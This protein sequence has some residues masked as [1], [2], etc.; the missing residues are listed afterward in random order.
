MGRKKR[1]RQNKQRG[2]SKKARVGKKPMSE[3]QKIARKKIRE[4]QKE[5][6]IKIQAKK[7]K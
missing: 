7:S 5:M 3:A 4:A 1:V 6:N 2:M